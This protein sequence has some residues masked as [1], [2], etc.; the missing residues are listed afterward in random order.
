MNIHF[1]H[2]FLG[3]PSDWDEVIA[4][5]PNEYTIYNWSLTDTPRIT[6]PS[7]LVGYS[8]GGRAA[9]HHYNEHV[10]GILLISTNIGTN[11]TA[12]RKQTEDTWLRWARE[13][14]FINRW[15]QQPLFTTFRTHP[16]Y[17]R[18]IF[19]RTLVPYDEI[20]YQMQNF[21]L[22]VT[23]NYWE[24]LS[25]FPIPLFFLYGKDDKKY[26]SMYKR[27]QRLS[28]QLI[29]NSGHVIPHENPKGCA[30]ALLWFL[31][32][33]QTSSTQNKTALLPS[34]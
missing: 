26:Y 15:Y 21:A 19:K 23:P 1:F 25:S 12:T 18:I 6:E 31:N 29:K 17:Q 24:S 27:C 20:E 28:K 32:S 33:L 4:A 3:N 22:S 8:M 14:N 13:P 2:G 30:Q 9:L 16:S 7:V 5:L 10:R 11:K 34:P